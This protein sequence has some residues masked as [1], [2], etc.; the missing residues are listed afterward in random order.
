MWRHDGLCTQNG[1]IL[2]MCPFQN[3]EI[4]RGT[5]MR[6]KSRWVLVV[7]AVGSIAGLN[8]CSSS[9][10]STPTTSFMWVATQGD[11]MV[12]SYTI[13][14][15]NGS[16]SLIGTNASPVATGVQPSA[17][18]ITPDGNSLF[19]VNS[20]TSTTS[21]TISAYTFKADGSLSVAGTPVSAGL[22]SVA[23][24]VDPAGKF[25]F[26]ANQ[27]TF[28][29]P[30]SG[31]ISVFGI[32]GTTLTPVAGSPFLTEVSTDVNGTGPSALAVSR[33]GNFLYVANQFSNTVESFS[34]DSAGALT[35]IATY[36]V[37]TNPSGLAFSRCAGISSTTATA[38]C[39]ATDSNNLFVSNS[40]SNNLS[41]F[42]ACIQTS[43]TCGTPNGTLTEVGSPVAAGVAPAAVL[44]NPSADFVYVVD[45]GSNQ[46]SEYQYSPATGVLTPL[47]A[48]GSGSA[49]VFSGGITSNIADNSTTFNWIILTNNGASSLSVFKVGATGKLTGLGSGPFAV[50]G[51]PSAILVR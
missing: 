3:F 30:A 51:Q 47:G 5:S 46:A 14:R 2:N 41:I 40:G 39:P 20:G 43:A 9:T 11:Q 33:A 25:L 49:S 42:S 13:S 32:Q 15:T 24:A 16:I 21:G 48:T 12:R 7:L 22:M 27:G 26:V 8:S 17:M 38:S 44:V 10:S 36:T 50:Q 6:M 23:L 19:I 37:G 1:L 45:R 18:A 31:T 34:Y 35:L 29:D 4:L 28:T